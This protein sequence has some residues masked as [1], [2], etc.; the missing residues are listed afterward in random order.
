MLV[1][2]E[3]TLKTAKLTSS[4]LLPLIAPSQLTRVAPLRPQLYEILLCF[5]PVKFTSTIWTVVLPVVLKPKYWHVVFLSTRSHGTHFAPWSVGFGSGF[6]V[7]VLRFVCDTLI[8]AVL[9]SCIEAVA[10]ADGDNT[11]AVLVTPFDWVSC[12]DT[13]HESASDSDADCVADTGASS[14][15][16]PEEEPLTVCECPERLSQ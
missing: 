16:V 13:D 5:T 2:V 6:H 3:L 11:G 10:E 9:V 14:D 8:A 4:H 7:A 15:F 1:A 12:C